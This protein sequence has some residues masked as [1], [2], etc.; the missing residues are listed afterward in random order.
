MRQPCQPA[1]DTPMHRPAAAQRRLSHEEYLERESASL[2][3]YEYAAGQ[4]YAMTGTG[5]ARDFI[6]GKYCVVYFP[7][8]YYGILTTILKAML[9]TKNDCIACFGGST[10][11]TG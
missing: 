8:V 2:V 5:D 1:M 10:I 6:Y 7:L 3:K 9:L 4:I 11:K